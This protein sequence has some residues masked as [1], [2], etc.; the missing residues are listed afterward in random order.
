MK[1]FLRV[2]L[3]TTSALL[4]LFPASVSAKVKFMNPW[5]EPILLESN[6]NEV[7]D[8]CKQEIRKQVYKFLDDNNAINGT[9]NPNDEMVKYVKFSST[10]LLIYTDFDTCLAKHNIAVYKVDKSMMYTGASHVVDARHFQRVAFRAYPN[11]PLYDS[12]RA[13]IDNKC[14]LSNFRMSYKWYADSGD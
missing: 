13:D 9:L 7:S 12:V 5:T 8:S 11:M 10:C 2:F 4:S 14:R 1:I 6:L 3:I